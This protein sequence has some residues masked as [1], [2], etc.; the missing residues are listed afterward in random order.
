MLNIKI[1]KMKTKSKNAES[2]PTNKT[3]VATARIL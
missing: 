2:N 3:A 1:P